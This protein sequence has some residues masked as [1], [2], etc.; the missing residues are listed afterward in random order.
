MM[1]SRRSAVLLVFL[2]T[3]LVETRS[4]CTSS[5]VIIKC[6]TYSPSEMRE[7]YF[8]NRT[9][10]VLDLRNLHINILMPATFKYMS[11]ITHIYLDG[12]RIDYVLNDTF[13]YAESLKLL[14]LR[15]LKSDLST[16]MQSIQ[17]SSLI[18]VDIGG[19]FASCSCAYWKTFLQISNSG[20]RVINSRTLPYC[21]WEDINTCSGK[22]YDTDS[23]DRNAKLTLDEQQEKT[24]LK[25]WPLPNELDDTPPHGNVYHRDSE[26]KGDL[27]LD[28]LN[29]KQDLKP[30]PLPDDLDDKVYHRD[31]EDDLGPNPPKIMNPWPLPDDASLDDKVYHRDSAG[32]QD[33]LG[34]NPPKMVNP[35]PLPDDPDDTGKLYQDLV[36]SEKDLELDVR[37]QTWDLM[38]LSPLDDLGDRAP[39]VD[40]SQPL[41]DDLPRQP[42]LD[43]SAK[44]AKTDLDFRSDELALIAREKKPLPPL[45]PLSPTN[46]L[47]KTPPKVPSKDELF[48]VD[49]LLEMNRGRF[50]AV[51]RLPDERLNGPPPIIP[52]T[53]IDEFGPL[54]PVAPGPGPDDVGPGPVDLA[55]GPEEI[56]PSPKH[57][58]HTNKPKPHPKQPPLKP[59]PNQRPKPQPKQRPKP[60]PKQRPT[61]PAPKQRQPKPEK[62]LTQKPASKK[63]RDNL[64]L[65]MS[66]VGVFVGLGVLVL[67]IINLTLYLRE[68][69]VSGSSSVF[70]THRLGR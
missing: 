31:S 64:I 6:D 56:T 15:S 3:S 27:G 35:W 12:S 14:S 16:F 33:D 69:A 46:D 48:Q 19:N 21:S 58:K 51:G 66:I 40:T 53:D 50:A 18:G 11:T 65:A 59:Q 30:G 9:L 26:T 44:S 47:D 32:L 62:G 37:K 22:I 67:C 5:D 54:P 49:K 41:K 17:Q 29:G 43:S 10:S 23:D 20:T 52:D 38:P 68:R 60:T 2:V 25:P 34:P 63:G 39:S 55:P 57:P 24:D 36:K 4:R 61:K 28:A 7:L 8:Q 70:S 1:S 13:R 45:P 42:P